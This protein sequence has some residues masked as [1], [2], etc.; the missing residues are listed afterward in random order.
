[1]MAYIQFKMLH[2]LI[3]T[4]LKKMSSQKDGVSIITLFVINFISQRNSKRDVKK[5]CGR[6][7]QQLWAR[8]VLL[9]N[10]GSSHRQERRRPIP[11]AKQQAIR[12]FKDYSSINEAIWETLK[13]VFYQRITDIHNIKF[14]Y[15]LKITQKS[16]HFWC[17]LRICLCPVLFKLKLRNFFDS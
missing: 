13:Y 6:G 15:R 7:L 8:D 16:T 4:K 5:E 14:L 12:S 17:C 3:K 11:P 10:R 1:M 9:K 2:L